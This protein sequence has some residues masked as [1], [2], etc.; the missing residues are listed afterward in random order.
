MASEGSTA[1]RGVTEHGNTLKDHH[2]TMPERVYIYADEGGDRRIIY[3][4]VQMGLIA[5]FLCYDLDK[6]I[7]ARPAAGC[8]YRNPIERC[9]SIANL[10]FQSVGLMCQSMNPETER[11]IKNLNSTAD[12]QIAFTMHKDLEKKLIDSLE[13]AKC[14]VETVLTHL[15]LKIR[16]LRYFLLPQIMKSRI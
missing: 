9:H 14:L 15:S 7:S 11:I 8:S 16:N 2:D 1:W 5:M 12:I 10:G 3:L 13:P 6:L 4:Q